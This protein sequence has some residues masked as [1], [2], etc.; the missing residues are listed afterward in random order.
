M[1]DF[2]LFL[3]IRSLPTY[4]HVQV[5]NIKNNSFSVFKFINLKFNFYLLLLKFTEKIW[6]DHNTLPTLLQIC[7]TVVLK[8]IVFY[9]DFEK[10]KI[11]SLA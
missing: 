6:I 10:Q 2:L 7:E 1:R 4:V 11:V 9:L 3:E 5:Q 8:I